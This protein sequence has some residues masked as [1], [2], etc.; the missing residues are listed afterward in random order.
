MVHPQ[1]AELFAQFTALL[2]RYL[3]NHSLVSVPQWQINPQQ[4]SYPSLYSN[5]AFG[6]KCNSSSS[7]FHGGLEDAWIA[8]GSFQDEHLKKRLARTLPTDTDTDNTN[9]FMDEH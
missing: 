6:N 5:G 7:Q 1:V 2:G 9:A 4:V 3:L 8:Q